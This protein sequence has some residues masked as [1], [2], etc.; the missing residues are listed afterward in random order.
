M[1]PLYMLAINHKIGMSA[2]MPPQTSKMGLCSLFFGNNY[3]IFTS[4]G[5]ERRDG[6]VEFFLCCA[7]NNHKIGMSARIPS[8]TL[9]MGPYFFLKSAYTVIDPLL[10]MRGRW[11]TIGVLNRGPGWRQWKKTILNLMH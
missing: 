10:R 2:R 1:K 6:A 3:V 8:Q 5:K 7:C 11:P 9:K 4:R